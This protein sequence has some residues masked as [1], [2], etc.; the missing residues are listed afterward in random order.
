MILREFLVERPTPFF[1]DYAGRY[2]DLPFLVR[3]SERDGAYVPGRFL[4]A[5]DLGETGE[6]AE[7]KTVLVDG[8]T[9]DPVVPN[10][11]SASATPTPASADGTSISAAWRRG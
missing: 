11:R 7:W 8:R 3:L 5:A 2:T 4:S 1:V 6:G 9:G 10:G